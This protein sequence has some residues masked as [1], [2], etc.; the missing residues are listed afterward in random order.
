M[1]YDRDRLFKKSDLVKVIIIAAIVFAISG[2][3]R[4]TGADEN[5]LYFVV[6]LTILIRNDFVDKR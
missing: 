4:L 1:K 5:K 2:F 6:I 3:A